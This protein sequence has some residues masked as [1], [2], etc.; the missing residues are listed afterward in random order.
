MTVVMGAVPGAYPASELGVDASPRAAAAQR[1]ADLAN[2]LF[3]DIGVFGPGA[4]HPPALWLHP[5]TESHYS[6]TGR[7]YVG[8]GPAGA[9]IDERSL[10]T[11]EETAAHESG[12]HAV[13][14]LLGFPGLLAAGPPGRLGEG[15]AEVFAGAAMHHGGDP[16]EAAWGA[17][18]LDPR[19]KTTPVGEWPRHRTDV[20]LSVTMDDVRAHRINPLSDAGGVH[21][22][23]GVVQEAHRLAAQVLGMDSMARVSADALHSTGRLTGFGAWARATIASA[24]KL[25]GQRGADAFRHAWEAVKVLHP[26]E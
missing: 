11:L 21:V 6:P 12:H 26:P 20:P 24:G 13:R 9:P 19:G 4:G 1:G 25:E 14:E 5:G 15:L 10:L 18:A 8:I 17:D 7:I 2:K 3:A 22:H 23:A 16:P